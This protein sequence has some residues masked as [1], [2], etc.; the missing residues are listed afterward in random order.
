MHARV[1]VNRQQIV[2]AVVGCLV[3]ENTTE[4]MNSKTVT[5]QI[6]QHIRVVPGA[7]CIVGGSHGDGKVVPTQEG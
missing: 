1:H 5:K 7:L 2:Y 6:K 4:I 3:R